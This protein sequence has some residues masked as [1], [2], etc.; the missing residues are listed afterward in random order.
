[1]EGDC[2]KD[3]DD[4]DDDGWLEDGDR[5]SYELRLGLEEVDGDDD[6]EEDECG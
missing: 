1:M 5:S 2:N 4:D 6:D 3:D